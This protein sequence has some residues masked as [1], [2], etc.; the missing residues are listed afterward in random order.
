MENELIQC[1]TDIE[2]IKKYLV[3]KGKSRFPGNILQNKLQESEIIYEKS[4]QIIKLF[5]DQKYI[6]PEKL[7]LINSTWE[8]IKDLYNK[9]LGF[10]HGV[11]FK[12][13][14]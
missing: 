7:K 12:N 9:I 6:K 8:N 1:I 10:N 13:G 11:R 4:K 2:S 3:K 5:S 14:L